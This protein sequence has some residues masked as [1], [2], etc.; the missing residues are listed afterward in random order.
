MEV[1]VA[2][3]TDGRASAL[4]VLCLCTGFWIHGRGDYEPMHQAHIASQNLFYWIPT[5]RNS[6][7]NKQR[8]LARGELRD[9]L[10][11]RID[12]AHT[13]LHVLTFQDTARKA[14][15]NSWAVQRKISTRSCDCLWTEYEYYVIGKSQDWRRKR[16]WKNDDVGQWKKLGKK[17]LWDLNIFIFFI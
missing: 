2:C 11:K 8:G 4:M 9:M 7:F 1:V 12:G 16:K 13:S 10:H 17:S 15:A 3:L 14:N 6:K 5:V